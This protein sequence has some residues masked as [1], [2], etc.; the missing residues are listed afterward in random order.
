MAE[1]VK[2]PSVFGRIAKYFREVKSEIKKVIWPSK[3][4]VINNTAVV[5][6]AI[7]VIGIIIYLLDMAFKGLLGLVIK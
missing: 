5:I 6:L 3:K 1:A 2:K 7:I 4:Q